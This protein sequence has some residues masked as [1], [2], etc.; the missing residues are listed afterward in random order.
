MTSM[1]RDAKLGKLESHTSTASKKAKRNLQEYFVSAQFSWSCS[2]D[3]R[4]SRSVHVILRDTLNGLEHFACMAVTPVN[5]HPI[6]TTVLG[7]LVGFSLNLR[8]STAYER[9]MEGRKVWSKLTGHAAAFSRTIWTHTIEREGEQGKEDLLAKISFLNLIIAFA[10]ALKHKVR[11]EPYI[12]YEDLQDL[13]GHLDT[14]ARDAGQP[15]VRPEVPDA[16]KHMRNILRVAEPNPR[17]E[18]KRAKRPLGNLPLEILGYMDSY[19]QTITANDTLR[20]AG[21][22]PGVMSELECFNDILVTADRILNT[23]LPIAY[24]IAISQITWIYVITL[25]FQ[26]V[27]LMGWMT[28]P[29]T[30]IAAYITL[31]FA[32]IGNEIE[33]PFGHEVND[34]P[35]ELYCAQIASDV[36]IIASR[37]AA[38]LDEYAFHADN[39]PL[40]PVSST[41]AEFWPDTSV[42]DIRNA[43]KMRAM[44]SRPAMWR[45][46]SMMPLSGRS[47]SNVSGSTLNTESV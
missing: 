30:M 4:F 24:T 13:V 43:L 47:G 11:F 45:R 19:I 25:P 9:Y 8:S 44:T 23:P 34:L 46:Q 1:V 41:G 40:Y 29:A 32:A 21:V 10:V 27:H 31:G 38:R 26:L 20:P 22:I 14:F 36:A 2:D 28:V 7:I 3:S 16:W 6:V 33:N 15:T 39:K 37:P 17:M 35:L 12:Q 18:L 5:V 42:Q